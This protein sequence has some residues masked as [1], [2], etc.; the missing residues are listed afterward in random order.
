MDDRAG[1]GEEALGSEET[2]ED[3]GDEAEGG[4]EAPPLQQHPKPPWNQP[5]ADAPPHP[6]ND[7]EPKQEAP[8]PQ[9]SLEEQT[10]Q[11]QT[12]QGR[13]ERPLKP[14]QEPGQRGSAEETPRSDKQGKSPSRRT[15]G[16]SARGASQPAATWPSA[17]HR[18]QVCVWP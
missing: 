11:S 10:N 13:T 14:Q 2:T 15:E 6:P 1:A 17:P 5:A 12:R 7:E 3:K 4:G 9:S 8:G 16:T 18:K